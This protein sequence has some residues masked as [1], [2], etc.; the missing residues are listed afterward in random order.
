MSKVMSVLGNEMG[1]MGSVTKGKS[2]DID[3]TFTMASVYEAKKDSIAKLSKEQQEKIKKMEKFTCHMVMNEKDGTCFFDMYADFK[4]IT[5]FQE[6]ISPVNAMS[7]VNSIGN[8]QVQGM[9]PKNDGVTH[10]R[11]D[12]KKFSKKVTVKSKEEI[13]KDYAKGLEKEG[14]GKE[15]ADAMSSQMAQS[16]E[17]IYQESDYIV[18]VGFPK[19]V[20]KVSIPNAKIS[21]DGKKVL[22]TYPMKEYMESKNLDFEVELE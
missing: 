14:M 3:T 5:E 10:Y 2:K 4:N 15:E 16:M 22:I 19:K 18:E 6:M 13:K 21:E 12:G 20:K 17:M 1:G 11:F 9:T 8:K 7:D